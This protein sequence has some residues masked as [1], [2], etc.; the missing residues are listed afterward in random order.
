M[1]KWTILIGTIIVGLFPLAC[2]KKAEPTSPAPVTVIVEFPTSTNTFT[3]TTTF[4][5]TPT[6]TNTPTLTITS[7]PTNSFTPTYTFTNSFTP[8]PQISPTSTGT[9]TPLPYD[10]QILVKTTNNCPTVPSVYT[11]NTTI[12]GFSGSGVYVTS[13]S[14]DFTLPGISPD[15]V[16]AVTIVFGT[17]NQVTSAF[18]PAVTQTGTFSIPGNPGGTYPGMAG[19]LVDCSNFT[20][21]CTEGPY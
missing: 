11:F 19:V 15:G 1:V 14:T 8:T 20:I 7:T 2:G 21:N 12:A 3:P 13:T 5:I 9:R 10:G 17:V 6:T 4:P 16:Y 18:S